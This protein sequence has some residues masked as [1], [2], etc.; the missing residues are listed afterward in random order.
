MYDQNGKRVYKDIRRNPTD[1]LWYVNVLWGGG[2]GGFVSLMRRYGYRTR[3]EARDGDI[4]DFDAA[5][6]KAPQEEDA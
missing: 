5:S 2:S 6:Y 1:S 4:S 3:A